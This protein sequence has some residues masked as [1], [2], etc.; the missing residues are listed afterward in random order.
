MDD[1]ASYSEGH[2][3]VK[4][5]APFRQRVSSLFGRQLPLY[6]TLLFAMC[7]QAN[8]SPLQKPASTLKTTCRVLLFPLFRQ[9]TEA[10]DLMLFT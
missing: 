4:H 6:S 7:L 1:T 3:G 10:L 2:P 8:H 5:T 9:E